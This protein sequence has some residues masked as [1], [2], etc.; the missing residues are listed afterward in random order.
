[1]EAGDG[2]FVALRC[3]GHRY[4]GSGVPLVFVGG[5]GVSGGGDDV[6]GLPLQDNVALRA[7]VLWWVGCGV[8]GDVGQSALVGPFSPVLGL[9]PSVPWDVLVLVLWPGRS[10][11]EGLY[12]VQGGGVFPG[13]FGQDADA[14]VARHGVQV[15]LTSYGGGRERF[16]QGCGAWG[17]AGRGV[18]LTSGVVDAVWDDLYG[19]GSNVTL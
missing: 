15:D 6:L 1:M 9:R 3:W 13:P 5:E 11:G 2:V 17:G 10:K 12:P 8:D 19:E 4:D 7:E 14:S 16:A 18:V